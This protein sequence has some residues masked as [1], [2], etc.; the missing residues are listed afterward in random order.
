MHNEKF[1]LGEAA[2]QTQPARISDLFVRNIHDTEQCGT[3]GGRLIS[4]VDA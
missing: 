3:R 2:S 4:P 1:L